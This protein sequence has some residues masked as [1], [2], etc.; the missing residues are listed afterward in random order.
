MNLPK[1]NLTRC[2]L[3]QNCQ[4]FHVD[5]TI[6]PI[7]P[8]LPD[9]LFKSPSLDENPNAVIPKT[10]FDSITYTGPVNGCADYWPVGKDTE[11]FKEKITKT[12]VPHAN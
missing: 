1:C 12:P 3:R 2:A 11:Y 10:E 5:G 9:G 7:M 8:F 6:E 4:R